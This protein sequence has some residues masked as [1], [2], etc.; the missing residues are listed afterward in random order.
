MWF[1]DDTT[2]LSPE[3]IE[4]NMGTLLITDAQLLLRS[5]DDARRL[6]NLGNSY[7]QFA[8]HII[9]NDW[10]TAGN[11]Q[12]RSSLERFIDY[13]SQELLC[14]AQIDWIRSEETPKGRRKYLAMQDDYGQAASAAAY[15]LYITVYDK[16]GASNGLSRLLCT[17]ITPGKPLIVVMPDG[18]AT[19]DAVHRIMQNP[20]PDKESANPFAVMSR[21][22][23]LGAHATI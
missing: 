23:Q 9:N 10:S 4:A 7:G 8:M 5:D 3:E 20:F 16:E 14:R 13:C 19:G 6:L 2:R 18:S 12:L 15:T 21:H 17:Q 11:N 1:V 22:M